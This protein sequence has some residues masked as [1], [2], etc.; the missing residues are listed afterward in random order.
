[1]QRTADIA[2]VVKVITQ[3]LTVEDSLF[4]GIAVRSCNCL[5]PDMCH[6]PWRPCHL[7]Q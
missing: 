5:A 4:R 1:M 7:R 6:V 3:L 2:L